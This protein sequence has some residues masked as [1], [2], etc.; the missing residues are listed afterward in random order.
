M[1]NELLPRNKTFNSELYTISKHESD[2]DFFH[3][4]VDQA[5]TCGEKRFRLISGPFLFW[6]RQKKERRKMNIQVDLLRNMF[7]TRNLKRAIQSD[8]VNISSFKL[9]LTLKVYLGESKD[10]SKKKVNS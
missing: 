10:S 5:V 8:K 7:K 2:S 4:A 6:G 9:I 1:R 3:K